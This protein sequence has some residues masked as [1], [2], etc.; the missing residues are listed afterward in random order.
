MRLFEV[1]TLAAILPVLVWLLLPWPRPRWVDFLPG[2]AVILMILHLFFEGYRWQML[3]AY[4]LVLLLFLITLPRL[5][6]NSPQEKSWS[7][8]SIAGSVLGLLLWLATLA[9]PY[10]LPVPQLPAVTGPYAIGTRTFHLIDESR[11]E[12]YTDDPA[13][14]REIMVQVWYPAEQDAQGEPAVYFEDLDVMGP[15]VAE[16]LGLPTYLLDHVNLANLDAQKDVPV[17]TANAPYPVLLFSHGLRSVRAQNTAMVR[18]LVSHGFVVATIDHTYGNALVV[19][20]DGRTALYDPDVLSGEGEPPHTSN[21]LVGVWAEDMS[22]VLDQLTTW[23]ETPEHGFGSRLDLSRVG[24]L[25]HSTGGGAAVE[26]CGVDERC[27]AGVGLDAWLVPV[28]EE[29]VAAGLRQPF[30]FL[31]ADQWEYEDAEQNDAYAE[32]LLGG[33]SETGYLA[34]IEGA[35]HYDFSDLPLFSPLTEQLNLSSDMNGDYVVE[36]MNRM[37]TAFFRQ[38]LKGEGEHLVHE[39]MIY[40][41]IS[42]V[43]NDR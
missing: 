21:T 37:T 3:P 14:K 36:M 12:I 5:R 22:A 32:A 19:F 27:R 6:V 34:T 42:V 43:G 41:E 8:W 16:R 25:G 38:V 7:A 33:M 18:E 24:A 11:G 28:S 31:R 39:T 15:V 23:N 29:I 26:F 30:L 10:L 20:P 13:D 40:P 4:V 9:L 2:T 1:L 35:V 17:L